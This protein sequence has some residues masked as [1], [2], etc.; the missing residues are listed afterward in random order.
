[1]FDFAAWHNSRILVYSILWHLIT[2]TQDH[3]LKGHNIECIG[4][5]RYQTVNSSISATW[6]TFFN[7]VMLFWEPR[8]RF[9]LCKPSVHHTQRRA[10]L[11]RSMLFYSRNCQQQNWVQFVMHI[12]IDCMIHWRTLVATV[13]Y[14]PLLLL[15]NNYQ[16][17][18]YNTISSVSAHNRAKMCIT[19]QSRNVQHMTK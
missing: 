10:S 14:E 15:L 3:N 8:C 12:D 13:A 5:H 16:Y 2:I 18:C 1:M 19:W 6:H 17:N 9:S 11:D 4:G 7:K